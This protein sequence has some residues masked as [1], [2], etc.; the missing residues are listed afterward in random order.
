M[1][2]RPNIISLG[3][4]LL[5]TAIFTG[6]G[7]AL[8]GT[9]VY[10]LI[11]TSPSHL[12]ISVG[13]A[14]GMGTLLGIVI[15]LLNFRRFIAPM[16][17]MIVSLDRIAE[18]NLQH[19]IDLNGVG[20]LKPV[21]VSLN[22]L[23]AKWDHLTSE[24]NEGAHRVMNSTS[25]ISEASIH[26][27]RAA[28]QIA[29]TTEKL[30]DQI[31]EQLKLIDQSVESAA[32]VTEALQ[33]MSEVSAKVIDYANKSVNRCQA[34]SES[35]EDTVE[36]LKESKESFQ[37]LERVIRELA[38]HSSRVNEI[39]S[40]ISEIAEQTNLLSLNAA[41]EAARAGEHGRGFAI[42]ADEVRKLAEESRNSSVQIEEIIQGILTEINNAQVKL[43]Q[44]TAQLDEGITSMNH[45][46][47]TFLDIRK[48]THTMLQE[49]V[50]LKELENN[51]VQQGIQLQNRLTSVR[52]GTIQIVNELELFT[53]SVEEQTASLN[54]INQTIESLTNLSQQL[55]REVSTIRAI[56]SDT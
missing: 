45:A 2:A 38:I 21:A 4:Y 50:H 26:N 23:I 25:A 52:E 15:S 29:A 51:V 18:G 3:K 35:I 6:I 22:D 42:V 54:D 56:S 39:T 13:V 5:R 55:K 8:I 37:S 24:I 14:T 30:G 40:M 12:Y 34:G 1:S 20:E 7:A 41:I 32:T 11:G 49:A 28:E 31:S 27:Y 47:K 43:E 19:R 9:L 44:S 48:D 36:R 53:G 46:R 16:R 17:C 10:Y 33:G